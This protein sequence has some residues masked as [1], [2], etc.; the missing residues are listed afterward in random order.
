MS[1]QPEAHLMPAGQ[2][3][4]LLV[5]MRVLQLSDVVQILKKYHIIILNNM[6]LRI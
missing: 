4:V 2:E 1:L 5:G 3:G 6:P